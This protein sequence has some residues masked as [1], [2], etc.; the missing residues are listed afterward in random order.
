[1]HSGKSCPDYCARDS[2][3]RCRQGALC[4]V[5]GGDADVWVLCW[6][7]VA[8]SGSLP[9]AQHAASPLDEANEQCSTHSKHTR[10]TAQQQKL[11]AARVPQPTAWD[12]TPC[13]CHA[14][15]RLGGVS[16]CAQLSDSRT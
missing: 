4:K 9:Q 10:M 3:Y 16:R 11:M 15:E 2:L 1:M 7:Y 12:H 8:L 13:Q 6:R 14:A 5:G